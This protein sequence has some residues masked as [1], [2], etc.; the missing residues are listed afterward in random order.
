MCDCDKKHTKSKAG[1]AKS[2]AGTAKSTK[3]KGT[4]KPAVKGGLKP[5]VVPPRKG[6]AKG[7]GGHKMPGSGML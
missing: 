3:S 1:A 7:P 2:K 4:A 6:Q 5:K